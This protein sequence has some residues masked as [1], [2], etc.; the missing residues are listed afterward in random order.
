MIYCKVRY[1]VFVEACGD[2][3]ETSV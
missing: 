1:T 2:I 3:Q